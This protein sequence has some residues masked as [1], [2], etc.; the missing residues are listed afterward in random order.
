MNALL[1]HI[2]CRV[3]LLTVWAVAS[4]ACFAGPF[5]PRDDAQV[6]ERLRSD[7]FDRE[8]RDLRAL[9]VRLAADPE[10][11][12]LAVEIARRCIARSRTEGDPRFLGHA[13]SALVRWW[14][15]AEPSAE[16]LVLRAI[17]QQSRHQF[18]AALKDLERAVQLAPANT[19]VWLTRATVLTVLG[20]YDE[21]RRSCVPLVRLAPPLVT[22]AAGTSVAV[23]TGQAE[24]ACE[25][26]RAV[27][28]QPTSAGAGSAEKLWAY[29]ILA[30]SVARLGRP[31]EAELHF[32]EAFAL[33]RRDPYLLG[34]YADFLLDAQ[35]YND[36]IEL[37]K[38]EVRID[39]LLL[40]LALAESKLN[41]LPPAFAQHCSSLQ[42]RFEASRLRGDALHQREEAR[43]TL[44]LL[45]RP[46]EALQLASENWKVQREP[47]DARILLEAAVAA[48][49]ADAAA[50]CLAFVRT[51]SLEN[52]QITRLAAQLD[53]M[54][55]Q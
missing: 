48:Q 55:S 12:A 40:R 25:R 47:A 38:D 19:Q 53:S 26:L 44:H 6:L 22:V 50:S 52:V 4:A 43:F 30:E 41:P 10:N 18:D 1:R 34:A 37:L 16:I 8:G 32:R 39:G 11:E 36:V 9:R 46:R 23:L 45:R 13:Q 17:I 5:I 2:R 42:A 24:A 28:D 33:G 54:P 21:A 20:R 3:F 31:D 7:P 49:A 27:L 15:Q 35:R 51:N 14:D 29:T